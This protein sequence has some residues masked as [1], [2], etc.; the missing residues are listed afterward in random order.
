MFL[1]LPSN[2]RY[3]D[4]IKWYYS[5]NN[6]WRMTMI[7]FC[8]NSKWILPLIPTSTT[9][10]SWKPAMSNRTLVLILD[11]SSTKIAKHWWF[12]ICFFKD[13]TIYAILNDTRVWEE[14][15]SNICWD[16]LI[17]HLLSSN[18]F[19]IKVVLP[20]VC[21]QI[22]LLSVCFCSRSISVT[23]WLCLSCVIS[24]PMTASVLHSTARWDG[25]RFCFDGPHLQVPKPQIP[26]VKAWI[27]AL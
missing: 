18:L 27:E 6:N 10:Q 13:D 21:F 19:K 12:I 1:S 8:T 23:S 22:K 25:R 9:D 24:S 2:Y 26:G 5:A 3:G 11:T 20:T 17:L 16:V 15:Q 7:I 4:I 14:Q